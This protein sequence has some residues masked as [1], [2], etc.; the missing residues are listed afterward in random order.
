MTRDTVA[1]LLTHLRNAALSKRHDAAV[2]QSKLNERIL[3]VMKS[4]GIIL[5]YRLEEERRQYL[6]ALGL[7]S[8]P[9]VQ[10]SRP[11]ARR[12]LGWRSLRKFAQGGFLLVSTPQGV[13]TAKTAYDRK[14]GGEVL[15]RLRRELV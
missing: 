4:E 15:A 10:V 11:G 6:V 5:S 14:L 3:S 7:Q 13:M 9:F 2:P 12:Y 8:L 1:Q